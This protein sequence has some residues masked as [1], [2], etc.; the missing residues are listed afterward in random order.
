MFFLFMVYNFAVFLKYK[1]MINDNFI[2]SPTTL[3]FITT[4]KCTAA[5]KD[6]C[7]SCSPKRKERLSLE[8]MK[9][10]ID[11]VI[12]SYDTIKVFVLT[13]GET[14]LLG[15]ELNQIVEYASS[16]GLIV[17]IVSNGYWAKTYN[18]AI[19][20]L[21]SLIRKGLK[22]LNFST[23]DDHQK[24]VPID[25]IING[26][27]ASLDLGLTVVVNVECS[28]ISKFKETTLKE[29]ERIK[30]YLKT[31]P[32]SKRLQILSGYW[33]PFTKSTKEE[34]D[35]VEETLR[36]VTSTSRCTSLFNT[37][38]ITPNHEIN[39]CC[40]ITS[41]Y[42]PFLKLG[43]AKRSP[44]KDLYNQQFNDFLK[45]WLFNEGPQKIMDFISEVD[46]NKKI[47]TNG[48][49]ICQIC[50]EIFRDKEK[51][52][53]LQNNYKKVYSNIMLKHVMRIKSYS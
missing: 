17:R 39:A 33:M 3:T 42:I 37:I 27:C 8:E 30:H 29:D 52:S 7:F 41:E 15:N 28:P 4:Y 1:V 32:F 6:C 5:C 19:K 24:F 25:N 45:I 35:K 11:Q 50:A 38:T 44:I 18:Y 16:K 26:I 51:L 20:K 2:I 49:H 22:E 23:G 36:V 12:D 43:N 46:P 53:I 10:Y 40:G 21:S 48:W 14:F 47:N 9:S 31:E 34:V 13:G